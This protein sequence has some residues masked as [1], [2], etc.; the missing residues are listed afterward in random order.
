[1]DVFLVPFLLLLKAIIGLAVWVVIADVIIGW[2]L[3][4]NIINPHN[5]FIIAVVDMLTRLSEVMLRPI[6]QFIPITLGTLDFS[7]VVLI[8]LLTFLENVL[9]RVIIKF[10]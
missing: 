8:L 1:M 4:I 2:L 5:R 10:N 3:M 6:R 9:T 7:P